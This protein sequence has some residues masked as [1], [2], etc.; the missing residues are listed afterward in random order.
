MRR[1]H[2]GTGDVAEQSAG[3]AEPLPAAKRTGYDAEAIIAFDAGMRIAPLSAD[4]LAPA[5][6]RK[7]TLRRR[8][9]EL[10]E[11]TRRVSC[12]ADKASRGRDGVGMILAGDDKA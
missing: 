3:M 7:H 4:H 12:G 8:R 11:E 5:C 9:V 1:D 6:N 2:A 10:G